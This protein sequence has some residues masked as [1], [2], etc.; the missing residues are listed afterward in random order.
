MS[1]LQ[2]FTSTPDR[3]AVHEL[4][5]CDAGNPTATVVLFDIGSTKGLH[6]EKGSLTGSLLYYT[7]A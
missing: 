4:S 1:A 3:R 2:R 6:K 7:V 5:C